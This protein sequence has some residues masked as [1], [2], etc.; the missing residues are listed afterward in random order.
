MTLADK[1]NVTPHIEP[2]TLDTLTGYVPPEYLNQL[3]ESVAV[4]N[5]MSDL[6]NE[7]FDWSYALQNIKNWYHL[8]RLFVQWN[9]GSITDGEFATLAVAALG[10]NYNDISD[11]LAEEKE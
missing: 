4:Y 2:D 1:D 7:H 11:K 3:R 5:T 6:N 8:T 10:N 9:E